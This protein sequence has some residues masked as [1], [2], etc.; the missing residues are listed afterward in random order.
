MLVD[1]LVRTVERCSREEAAEVAFVVMDRIA[2]DAGLI[3]LDADAITRDELRPAR[4]E[5]LDASIVLS[6]ARMTWLR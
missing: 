5:L 1:Q 4:A 3:D 2:R 6:P